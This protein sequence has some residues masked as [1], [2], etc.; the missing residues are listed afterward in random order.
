MKNIFF[1]SLLAATLVAFTFP[2]SKATFK[3]SGNCGQCKERIETALD[4]KGI[5]SAEWN[6]DTKDLDVVYV[7]E[8]ITLEQI[9]HLVA[10]SGHDT[11]KEK[12]SDEAYKKLPDC[13][14][15]REHPNTHHD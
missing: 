15:Y 14:L 2:P 12:A 7:P 11:D 10:L 6:I 8:K 4:Q 5:K 1:I 13:C 3:V 9:H